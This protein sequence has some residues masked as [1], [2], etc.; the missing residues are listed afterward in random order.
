MINLCIQFYIFAP[1]GE[2][3]LLEFECAVHVG[4]VIVSLYFIPINYQ[5]YHLFT[6][7][8]PQL[9]AELV[10]LTVYFARAPSHAGILCFQ[11]LLHLCLYLFHRGGFNLY[12]LC[13]QFTGYNCRFF[14]L[15]A[16]VI[17]FGQQVFGVKPA[18]I[19]VPGMEVCSLAFVHILSFEFLLFMSFS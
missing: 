2:L 12:L 6:A 3:P 1:R 15:S 16:F 14:Q 7:P 10:A 9:H 13:Q 4:C 18:G 5:F 19:H 11:Y 17:Q 8:P